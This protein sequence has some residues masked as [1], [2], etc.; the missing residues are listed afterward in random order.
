M[1]FSVVLIAKNE[2][3][4]LPRLM[5]SL[6]EFRTRGGEIILLDTGSTDGTPNLARSYGVIVHEVGERFVREVTGTQAEEINADFRDPSE[7]EIVRAGDRYFDYAAARNHAAT[8]ASNDMLAT[9][10]CDEAYTVFDIER[11]ESAIARGVEQL[12]YHFVF[13]HLPDGSPGIQFA[14]CKFY[15]RRK[16]QWTGVIHEVLTGTAVKEYVDFIRLEHFQLPDERRGRYLTGLAVEV[17]NDPGND[18]NCHYFARELMYAGRPLS[19]AREFR[20][21]IAMDKWP[22]ERAQSYVF[23][24]DCTSD[25][26]AYLKAIQI[27]PTR[28][29]AF[30]RLAW[31]GYRAGC[32]RS[33]ATWA[34]AA[35][36]IP[37][38]HYYGNNGADYGAMPH[39][40]LYWAHWYLGDVELS[41]F[42]WKR[43]LSLEP[44]NPKYVGDWALFNPT[45]LISIVIPTLGRE[46]Q[47]AALIESIPTLA[48]YP[49]IEIV[50][51][52]DSFE[53]R[54]GV[55]RTLA[56][57]VDRARGEY[58]LFLGNDCKPRQGFVMQ[59]MIV[60]SGEPVFVALNDGLWDGKLAT[61]WMAHRSLKRDGFFSD[62]YHHVGCDNELTARMKQRG[63]YRY[64][65]LSN[66]GHS[67]LDD[68]VRRI[69]WDA[70]AV[71]SDRAILKQRSIQFGFA[72]FL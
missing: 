61:H 27:D 31:A 67:T 24:G 35:I 71:E 54:S 49:N 58:I 14:H 10:D 56:R 52:H 16:L 15:D 46:E 40:M 25:Q 50:V 55:A 44:E 36:G 62:A 59:A 29:E 6:C 66:I 32:H 20:R 1:T 23:L 69:A 65:P 57:A 37:L 9:P 21:H 70:K 47:L 5:E 38:N 63:V 4:T 53:N 33:T 34:G 42:H 43:A 51:E 68:S 13:S 3:R 7:P 22:A 8:L 11:I 30:M 48:G 39:E 41:R 72:P 19:A 26:S 17:R 64:A 60:A 12:E 2:S 28:R 18:R 45:P